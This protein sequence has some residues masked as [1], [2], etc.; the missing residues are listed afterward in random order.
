MG[1]L[2]TTLVSTQS[3][4]VI[5]GLRI[6]H[7]GCANDVGELAKTGVTHIVNVS[8]HEGVQYPGIQYLRLRIPDVPEFD[9]RSIF[10]QTNAFI[11]G[12]RRSG[13]VVLVVCSMGISRSTSVV[14]GYLMAFQRMSFKDALAAVARVR[15]IVNPN[16][17]FR[18][19]LQIYE[20]ELR[21]YRESNKGVSV[22][23]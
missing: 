22:T 21:E 15:P 3:Q 19:F 2:Y 20:Q 10:E 4:E 8:S 7:I 9:I 13:G 17:G 14:V 1:M 12:G 5:P 16:S 18:K 11:H 6:G 23:R